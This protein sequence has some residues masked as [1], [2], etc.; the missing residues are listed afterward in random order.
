MQ[1]LQVCDCCPLL[2]KVQCWLRRRRTVRQMVDT[3]EVTDLSPEDKETEPCWRGAAARGRWSFSLL[4]TR[5]TDCQAAPWSTG[6]RCR[7][8]LTCPSGTTVS[9][10][11]CPSSEVLVIFFQH[12]IDVNSCICRNL[13]WFRASS[14]LGVV[15]PLKHINDIKGIWCIVCALSRQNV[16]AV[17]C[18]DLHSA[19]I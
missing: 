9:H 10:F 15:A 5:A 13:N 17:L 12:L 16:C 11:L 1:Q 18:F 4:P 3:P 6:T 2:W 19:E 7:R 14:L 8:T